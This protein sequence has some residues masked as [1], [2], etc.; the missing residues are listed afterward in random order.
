MSFTPLRWI[1]LALIGIAVHVLTPGPG[2][3]ADYAT[4]DEMDRYVAR[5]AAEDLQVL[6]G[7]KPRELWVTPEGKA[8]NP[9]T[10]DAPLDLKTVFV[11]SKIA[12]AGTLVWVA[13][14]RYVVGA[15]DQGPDVKGTRSQPIIY[16]AVPGER[17]TVVGELRP[18]GDHVWIWGLEITGEPASGVCVMGGDGVKVIN[19]VIHENGPAQKPDKRKP[20]G[21]G[22]GGWDVGNDHEFYGNIIYW[23][24]WYT[25]DHGIYSQNQAKHT[26]KRYVDNIV[27]ENAGFGLHL[28]GSSPFLNG[29]YVE[30]NFCFATTM[31]PR[32]PDLRQPQVNILVGGSKPLNNALLRNNLTWHPKAAQSK[33]GVDVGYIGGPNRNILIEGNYFTGGI[34]AMELK[35]AAEATVRKNTFWAPE[36]MVAVTLAAGQQSQPAQE[37]KVVFENN[38]YVDNGNFE[39]ARL[40]AQTRSAATDRVV[41]ADSMGPA[42]VFLRP[43]RY[44]PDRVHLAVHNWSRAPTVKL[45]L[46]AVLKPGQRFSIVEVHDVWASP[47]LT[48]AFQGRPVELTLTGTYAPDFGCYLLMKRDGQRVP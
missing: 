19:C 48:G 8:D 41:P 35:N 36:G 38:T 15:V 1:A 23:N 34:S 7:L 5:C 11:N 42:V 28:Y 33:R 9:G 32:N 29:L 6:A 46:A 31:M 3:R 30:G 37:P 12:T 26:A 13:G 20:S 24:G 16:R 14:G 2:L 18:R 45:D 40:R 17:A 47:V 27:F 25:L 22:I 21:Q 4:V 10:K 43:N 39:L 44:E